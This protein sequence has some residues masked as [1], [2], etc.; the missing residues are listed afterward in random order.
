MCAFA[1]NSVIGPLQNPYWSRTDGIHRGP[2]FPIPPECSSAD[3]TYLRRSVTLESSTRQETR[4][5]TIDN[6]ARSGVHC[7]GQ[8]AARSRSSK[9][10]AID[11]EN[12]CDLPNYS[13]GQGARH[14]RP[15]GD[16]R[17]RHVPNLRRRGGGREATS[18][19]G[20]RQ[21]P[22]WRSARVSITPLHD[23]R[24]LVLLEAEDTERH[25]FSRLGEV[26]YTREGVAFAAGESY[27][28][29][30]VTEGRG[31]IRVSFKGKIYVFL[32]LLARSS[33]RS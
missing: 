4:H 7:A 28:L 16:P 23:T 26:G 6:F 24:L 3:T 14:I 20:R 19:D 15:R 2:G 30:V 9:A 32:R 33:T 18:S 8:P 5:S 22:G 10:D 31:T 1:A 29:C 25:T 13:G 12:H 21:G 17:R 11:R 27:P